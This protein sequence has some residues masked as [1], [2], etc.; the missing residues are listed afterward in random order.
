VAETYAHETPFESNSVTDSLEVAQ[1]DATVK[2][3]EDTVAQAED[4]QAHDNKLLETS[5]PFH[6]PV[7]ASEQHEEACQRRTWLFP[8]IVFVCLSFQSNQPNKPNQSL[9]TN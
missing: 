4:P 6:I 8:R 3:K 7:P 5:G 9:R 2:V 1:S